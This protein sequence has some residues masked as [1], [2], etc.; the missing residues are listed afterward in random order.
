M[1][2]VALPTLRDKDTAAEGPMERTRGGGDSKR[3]PREAG[4]P[5]FP[6]GDGEDA[7]QEGPVKS[8]FA[9]G[10]GSLKGNRSLVGYC[11]CGEVRKLCGNVMGLFILCD[12][13]VWLSCDIIAENPN[14]S[15][16]RRE[17][18]SI[19]IGLVD[20]SIFER[21]LSSNVR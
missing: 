21:R 4:C 16:S 2:S 12:S 3:L 6:R 5:H 13:D 9:L 19:S 14:S 15:D 8:H 1:P 20:P 10:D 17:P 11:C 7:V 18:S